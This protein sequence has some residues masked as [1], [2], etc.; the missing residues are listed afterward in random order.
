MRASFILQVKARDISGLGDRSAYGLPDETGVLILDVPAGSPAAKAGLQKEDVIR[1]C[2][3]QPVKTVEELQKTRD[4]A[5]GKKLTLSIIRKQGQVNVELSDYAYVV[6]ETAKNPK[7]DTVPLAQESAVLP[8]KVSS[9][10]ASTN[11]DPIGFLT[12]GKVANSYGPIFAN[13]IE[14]GM[15]KLDLAAVKSIAQVN[16][17][18]ALDVRS[19]QNFVLYGSGAES[20]PGGKSTIQRFSRRLFLSTPGRACLPPSRPP[21]Y[22]SATISRWAV[23]A[24]WSGW[25]SRL[26]RV[27]PRIRHFRSCRCSPRSERKSCRQHRRFGVP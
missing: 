2:N 24:G 14:G 21:A 16:T 25:F 5:A 27:M 1:S 8:A 9:G 12:D 4:M 18:S 13:G 26:P 11:N 19:Q 23:I 15:Y 7:F 6:T 22:A 10:G 3:D 17:F 20:D